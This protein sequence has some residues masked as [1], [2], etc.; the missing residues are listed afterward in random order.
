MSAMSSQEAILAERV[1]CLFCK[2]LAELPGSRR[3]GEWRRGCQERAAWERGS[4]NE[5]QK[6]PG[7]GER[8]WEK[9]IF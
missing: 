7:R 5:K 9:V 4:A 3:R 6:H 1:T 8:L 2:S